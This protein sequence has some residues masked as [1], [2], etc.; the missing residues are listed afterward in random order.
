[1]QEFQ[2]ISTLTLHY[3]PSNST[4]LDGMFMESIE[5][6]FKLWCTICDGCGSLGYMWNLIKNILVP[7]V[8]AA[9]T[10]SPG[11]VMWPFPGSRVTRN[12]DYILVS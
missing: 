4:V 3:K 11:Q 7:S 12:K 6:M 2:H 1:M 8:W 5:T 10:L 9:I